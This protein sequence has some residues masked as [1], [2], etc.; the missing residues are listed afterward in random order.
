MVRIREMQVTVRVEYYWE[1]APWREKASVI[2]HS[3]CDETGRPITDCELVRDIENQM[4]SALD[5]EEY[6]KPSDHV[7]GT[8]SCIADA[9]VEDVGIQVEKSTEGG[10]V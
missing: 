1:L 2:I 7:G 10:E 8:P 9:D 5:K 4:R 3:V 6:A